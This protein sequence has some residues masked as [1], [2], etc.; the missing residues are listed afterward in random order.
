MQEHELLAQAGH[1]LCDLAIFFELRLDHHTHAHVVEDLVEHVAE[2]VDDAVLRAVAAIHAVVGALT[3]ILL[4][5]FCR[6][7]EASRAKVV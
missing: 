5:V 1:R 4:L 2:L 6:V 7:I 3:F